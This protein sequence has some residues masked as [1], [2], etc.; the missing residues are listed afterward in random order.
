MIT[1]L[2]NCLSDQN[3]AKKVL[4]SGFHALLLTLTILLTACG[5]GGSSDTTKEAETP[6]YKAVS[7]AVTDSNDVPLDGVA[8]KIIGTA[9]DG[10][11]NAVNQLQTDDYGI[12]SFL[13]PFDTQESLSL[14]ASKPGYLTT[15]T[16]I[17]LTSGNDLAAGRAALVKLDQ[18]S[19]PQGSGYAASSVDTDGEGRVTGGVNVQVTDAHDDTLVTFSIPQNA[20]LKTSSG[21]AVTGTLQVDVVDFE[22]AK[23]GELMKFFPGGIH[24]KADNV[25]SEDGISFADDQPVAFGGGK[26]ASF[27]IRDSQGNVVK[28]IADGN[29]T[30]TAKIAKTTVNPKTGKSVAAGDTIEIWSYDEETG[31]WRYEKEATLTDIGHSEYLGITYTTSHLSYWFSDWHYYYSRINLTTTGA[32]GAPLKIYWTTSSNSGSIWGMSANLSWSQLK[33]VSYDFRFTYF[34]RDLTT[35]NILCTTSECNIGVDLSGLLPATKAV[36]IQMSESC[37]DGSNLKII[38]PNYAYAYADLG[39]ANAQWL[40]YADGEGRWDLLLPA[41][42]ERVLSVY[43]HYNSRH[44]NYFEQALL[45]AGE[46]SVVINYE[47]KDEFCPASTNSRPVATFD[48]FEVNENAA[49]AG[50]LTG[51]DGENDTLTYKAISTPLHGQLTVNTDGSFS[52]TPGPDYFGSDVFYYVVNDGKI[53]SE[54]KRVD[55]TVV[56]VAPLPQISS[57]DANPAVITAGGSSD[58][59]AVFLDG[60]ATI[61]N[62]VGAVASGI[63]VNVTPS[64]TTE[65]NLTVTNVDNISVSRLVTVTVVN[66]PTI[67]D[68][69][70]SFYSVMEGSDVE[71]TALFADGNATIDNGVGSV[72]SGIPVTVTPWVTTTYILTVTNAAGT[73]VTQSLTIYVT[74]AGAEC[75]VDVHG[76]GANEGDSGITYY[77]F[78][79]SIS[80]PPTT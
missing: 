71:L 10:E 52:Y 15:G 46:T 55:A 68:F 53:D 74:P 61:S 40:G 64:A 73:Q 56:P 25:P 72:T 7:F 39:T 19:L 14:I 37:A 5:G 30:I 27:S 41:N 28:N 26:F 12:I 57:F 22:P 16:D 31:R 67:S 2:R 18:G 43:N 51:S 1:H 29:F 34:G 33:N 79:V 69:N 70:A 44:K 54:S 75:D 66:D 11:G 9:F 38:V 63:P 58:L 47:L 42:E 49:F 17:N 45:G 76:S 78:D 32:T 8:V 20:Q 48:A 59:T 4:T 36:T 65:Y 3:S 6:V 50:Q 35:K 13:S 24:V 21:A 77:L 80:C 23:N 60:N 62:G